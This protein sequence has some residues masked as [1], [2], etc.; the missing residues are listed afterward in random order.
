MAWAE[1]LPAGGFRGCY[2][3]AEGQ[4]RS[5]RTGDDGRPFVRRKQAEA[6]ATR[7]EE[8]ARATGRDLAADK[9]LWGDWCDQWFHTR[10][11][12]P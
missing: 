6:W 5:S 11:V 10:N 4:K 1:Q 12:A 2:R 9:M 7:Q 3:N 8:K